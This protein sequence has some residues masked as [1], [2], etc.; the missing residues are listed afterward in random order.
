METGLLLLILIVLFIRWL[1]LRG[2]MDELKRRLEDVESSPREARLIERI[3]AL[4]KAVEELRGPRPSV[5]H[6]CSRN[7]HRSATSARGASAASQT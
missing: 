4:E 5:A 6:A 3:Y 2:R 1:V 7:P